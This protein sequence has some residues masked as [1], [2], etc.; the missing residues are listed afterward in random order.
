M[1]IFNLINIE[2]VGKNSI[3]IASKILQFIL[4]FSILK[5]FDHQFNDVGDWFFAEKPYFN[6]AQKTSKILGVNTMSFGMVFTFFH[7]KEQKG[8]I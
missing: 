5:P 2:K 4:N 7:M 8:V 3:N 1:D 6:V